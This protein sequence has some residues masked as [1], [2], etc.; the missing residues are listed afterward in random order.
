M[1]FGYNTLTDFSLACS[2]YRWID[3]VK[4]ALVISHE[5]TVL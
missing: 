5:I 4:Q 3:D 1:L 2:V